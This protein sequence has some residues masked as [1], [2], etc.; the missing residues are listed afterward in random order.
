M[1][2]KLPQVPILPWGEVLQ[3]K[4]P[5]VLEKSANNALMTKCSASDGTFEY[6]EV[7]LPN[8][9]ET[10]TWHTW[11]MLG[12]ISSTMK[13]DE[14]PLGNSLGRIRVNP[15]PEGYPY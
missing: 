10:I 6:A 3:L 9:L 12:Y 11:I 1:A 8:V 5:R 15:L 4:L 7:R 14:Y 13:V 2:A